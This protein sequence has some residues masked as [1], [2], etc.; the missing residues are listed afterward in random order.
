MFKRV[1]L[2]ILFSFFLFDIVSCVETR[3]QFVPTQVS[4]EELDDVLENDDS[5]EHEL[6]QDSDQQ[7]PG[8]PINQKTKSIIDPIDNT[9]TNDDSKGIIVPFRNKTPPRRNPQQRSTANRNLSIQLTHFF[10]IELLFLI[11]SI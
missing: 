11:Y 7:V 3:D 6:I 8:T 2:T 10:A 1:F 9:R 4:D 5:D